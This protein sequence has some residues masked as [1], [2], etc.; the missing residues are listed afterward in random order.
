MEIVVAQENHVPEI[1][2]L[3][4]EFARFHEPFDPR[5][6]MKDEVRPGYETHL[7]EAITAKD[8]KVLVALDRNRVV[9]Y[10]IALIRKPP[11]V[12]QRERYGYIDEMTVTADY[13][14]RSIGSKLLKEI[15]DWFRSE[16]LDFI[17]LSVAAKNKV[18]YSF[19][20]KHGFRDYLHHL[21]LKP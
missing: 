21:Y 17:E 8:A 5:Y 2:N 13:R 12:F 19:W 18:G 11:P 4:E 1:I 9:G 15:L 14:R 16:N 7:R 6:P 3:W 20:K 10:V